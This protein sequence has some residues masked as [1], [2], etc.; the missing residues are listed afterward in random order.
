LF[1][2]FYILLSILDPRPGLLRTGVF[3][4][5]KDFS[6]VKKDFSDVKKDFSDVKKDFS[7]VKKDFSDVKKDF[8]LLVF[9][10]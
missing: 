3:D 10:G 9:C 4:V 7:D 5:K 1:L 2:T 6:D 8:T